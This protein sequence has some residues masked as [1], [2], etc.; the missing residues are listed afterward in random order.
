MNESDMQHDDWADDESAEHDIANE[1]WRI[2]ETPD[3]AHP[4]PGLLDVE[5]W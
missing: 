1:C 2:S 4:D 5:S 3:D